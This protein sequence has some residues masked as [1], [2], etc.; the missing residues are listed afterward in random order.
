MEDGLSDH[1]VV[2]SPAGAGDVQRDLAQEV[3]GGRAEAREP[4]DEVLLLLAAILRPAGG[5]LVAGWVQ[6]YLVA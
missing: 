3:E 2:A 6:G 1:M 4:G 5:L